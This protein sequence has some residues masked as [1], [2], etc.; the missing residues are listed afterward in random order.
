MLEASMSNAS[1]LA[2]VLAFYLSKYDSAALRALG[3]KGFTAAFR[4]IGSRLGISAAAVKNKRDDFDPLHD[5]HRAGW[6][7]RDLGPSRVKVVAMFENVSFEAL[8]SFA[9]DLLLD[10]NYRASDEV[11]SLL[12]SLKPNETQ[13]PARVFVPRGATGRRAEELFIYLFERGELPLKGCLIDQRENGIGYDFLVEGDSG[14]YRIEVKGCAGEN[15]G[16]LLTDKEWQTARTDPAYR[17]FVAYRLDGNPKWKII[18]PPFHSLQ[19]VRQVRTIV[20][21]S[22]QVPAKQLGIV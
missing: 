3:Y 6:H 19:P 4:D 17:F 15:T 13:T 12:T 8:T 21:V 10:V 1:R 7:Q 14:K 22:W 11:Q 16:I 5:N 18:E 9:K 2:L 20:Q